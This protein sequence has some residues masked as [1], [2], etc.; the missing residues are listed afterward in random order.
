LAKASEQ[1]RQSDVTLW[2]I[3]ALVTAGLAV[4]GANVAAVVPQGIIGGLHQSRLAGPSIE[5]LRQQVTSLRA[6]TRKLSRENEQLLAR[7]TLQE[8]AAGEVV[9]RVGALEVTVPR[10]VEAMPDPALVDRS[11]FTAS[12]AAG[13]NAALVFDADGGS[14]VVR[15]SPLP[16]LAAPAAASQPLPA[17]L[18]PS[19]VAAAPLPAGYGVALGDPVP[20]AAIAAQWQNLSGKLGPLLFGLEPLVAEAATGEDKRIVVGPIAAIGEARALCERLERSAV[21]C[22]PMPYLGQPL[23]GIEAAAGEGG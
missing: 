23:G 17:P 7:F 11:N 4:F 1:F 13:D 16:Q 5:T 10:L 21:A 18:E 19:A 2:G 6:E 14:V 8:Q 15:Q 20:A 12:I 3:V 9:R 22:T